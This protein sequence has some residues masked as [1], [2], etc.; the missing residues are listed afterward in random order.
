M[1]GI[2]TVNR[3]AT[4]LSTTND[5]ATLV[6][7]AAKPLRVHLIDITGAGAAAALNTV[8]ISRS[9]GGTSGTGGITPTPTDPS[10]PAASFAAYTGW[11]VQPT[12]G[13][14]LWRA[15]V[16]ALNGKDRFVASPG[17]EI[18]VPAG[19]QMSIRSASGTSDVVLNMI[20]EEIG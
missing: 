5:L 3:A 20:V 7:A 19:G 2:Y 1:S 17:L 6:A 4:A 12:L 8:L 15:F 10:M 18:L 14:T 16:Q 13:A 9:T 11:S